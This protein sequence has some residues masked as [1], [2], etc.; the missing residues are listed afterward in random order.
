MRRRRLDPETLLLRLRELGAVLEGHFLLTSGKH[1]PAFVQCSQLL[2]HPAEAERVGRALAER[3]RDV[4]A[5]VVVGPAMGGVILAHEVARA[6]GTRSCFTEKQD[7]GQIFRR[8]FRLSPEDRVVL[9]EDVLTTGGSVLRS[10]AAVR[11]TGARV[12]G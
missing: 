1:S 9:V 7:G 2:Q 4:G 12:V 5:T 10:A 8:G 3:L 11:A 6:L